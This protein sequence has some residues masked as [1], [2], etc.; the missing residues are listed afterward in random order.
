ML[1]TRNNSLGIMD[2][3]KTMKGRSS[4]SLDEK[5]QKVL[6][7]TTAKLILSKDRSVSQSEIVQALIKMLSQNKITL[8]QLEAELE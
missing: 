2:H 7:Q 1:G 4:F 6:T 8:K 5:Y 3:I